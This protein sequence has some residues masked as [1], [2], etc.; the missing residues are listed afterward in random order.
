M[1][2][3]TLLPIPLNYTVSGIINDERLYTRYHSRGRVASLSNGIFNALATRLR[4][5]NNL[6]AL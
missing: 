4:L 1:I 5:N 6:L 2:T 3:K